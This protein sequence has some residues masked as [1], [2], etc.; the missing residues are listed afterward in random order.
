MA[1]ILSRP[2]TDSS[3]FPEPPVPETYLDGCSTLQ[4]VIKQG[5]GMPSYRHLSAG[6]FIVSASV[7]VL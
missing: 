4:D 6:Y 2:S 7:C 5:Q 3:H 1:S